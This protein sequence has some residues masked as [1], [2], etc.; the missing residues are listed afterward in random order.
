MSM[1]PAKQEGSDASRRHWR[2]S[3]KPQAIPE[4]DDDA[5][6][7]ATAAKGRTDSS[8]VGSTQPRRPTTNYRMSLNAAATR[9]NNCRTS[10][11]IDEQDFLKI[12]GA[13]NADIV[14]NVDA[15]NDAM[16]NAHHQQRHTAAKQRLSA[17]IQASRTL[18]QD[19][20]QKFLDNLVQISDTEALLQAAQVLEKDPLYQGSGTSTSLSNDA[21]LLPGDPRRRRLTETTASTVEGNK[22]LSPVRQEPSFR[23]EL[24]MEYASQMSIIHEEEKPTQQGI[25]QK[26]DNPLTAFFRKA[27]T[28]NQHD[29][30]TYTTDESTV[31]TTEEIIPFVILGTHVDDPAA[32]P[33]VLSPPLMDAL[34][35]FLPFA[36]RQDNYWLKYSLLRDVSCLTRKE[37][38]PVVPMVVASHIMFL[39]LCDSTLTGSLH[40]KSFAVRA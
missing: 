39:F 24:W 12:L 19:H 2:R 22:S 34:R 10:L 8:P 5:N 18:L 1:S 27:F 25:K 38:N 15:K 4:L 11:T 33:H 31:T 36:I 21:S 40:L 28:G 13:E 14:V 6:T 32:S 20:E 16:T 23:R 37:C 30:S 9:K 35:P 26:K 7:N 3:F 29:D 17:S